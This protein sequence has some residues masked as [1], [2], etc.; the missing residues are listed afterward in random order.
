MTTHAWLWRL[1]ILLFPIMLVGLSCNEAKDG[2]VYRSIDG[3]QSWEQKT[4]MSQQGKNIVSISD[5]EVLTLVAHPTDSNRVY[6]G[7]KGLGMYVTYNNGEQWN[8]TPIKQGNILAIGIDSI[9]PANMFVAQDNVVLRSTDAGETWQQSYVE[10][11]K[12]LV[13]SVLVDSYDNSRIYAATSGGEILKSVD[14]GITWDIHYN[15]RSSITKLL[16]SK[17]DTRIIYVLDSKGELVQTT[18]G[19]EFDSALIDSADYINSGWHKLLDEKYEDMFSHNAMNAANI[20]LDPQDNSIVYISTKRGLMKGENN[21]QNWSDVINIFG[22]NDKNN[23]NIKNL[24]IAADANHTI[25]YT[26]NKVIYKSSDQGNNWQTLETFPS[27]RILSALIIDQTNANI[28]Y[29]GTRQ[30]KDEGGGIFKVK[31]N[32]N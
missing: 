11:N 26:L 22:V 6:L 7:S 10:V 1:G 28:V 4:F 12:K 27:A 16:M 3:G 24:T 32:T 14:Y 9:N 17:Q 31:K 21:G 2:G 8:Y 19:G 25:Y 18:N 23:S 13:Y 15:G 20:T 29:I 30:P 5:V